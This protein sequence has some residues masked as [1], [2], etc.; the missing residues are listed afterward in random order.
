MPSWEGNGHGIEAVNVK[1]GPQKV[2]RSVRITP[3]KVEVTSLN[4]PPPLL[5]TCQ[6]KKKKNVELVRLIMEINY[7]NSNIYN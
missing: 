6:K 2:T 4:P 1:L 5:R 3:N 7:A